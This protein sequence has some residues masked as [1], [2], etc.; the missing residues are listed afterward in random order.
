MDS[1]YSEDIT[2]ELNM[3]STQAFADAVAESMAQKEY[4]FEVTLPSGIVERDSSDDGALFYQNGNLV[5]GYKTIHFEKGILP[6]VHKNQNLILDRLKEYLM[7]QIDL[8]GFS[9][10][11]IDEVRITARFSN[12][13]I[14]YTHYIL[15]FGQ[16]GTQYDIW[17]NEKLLDSSTVTSIIS[18]A[19]LVNL[20]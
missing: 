12:G 9:G 18:N 6:E 3:I 16:V 10:E 1:L 20:N 15:S 17:F 19:E 8:S 5:G 7:D 4:Q 13:D 11:I 14:E 2:D